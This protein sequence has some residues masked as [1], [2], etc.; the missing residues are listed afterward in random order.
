MNERIRCWRG[1]KWHA[2]IRQ[3]QTVMTH[4]QLVNDNSRG[5]H[6]S[7]WLLPKG[8]SRNG[9]WE[10]RARSKPLLQK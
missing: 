8:N 7:P 3:P 6:A 4:C 2:P 10:T 5:A 1:L 9:C